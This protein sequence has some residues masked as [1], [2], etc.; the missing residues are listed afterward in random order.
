MNNLVIK[1]TLGFKDETQTFVI[2]T[3]QSDT[4]R[5]VIIQIVDELTLIDFSNIA[6][7]ILYYENYSLDLTSSID[8]VN[9][10][11]SFSIDDLAGNLTG[12]IYCEI[13]LKDI[14]GNVIL[15]TNKFLI[16][17]K[18]IGGDCSC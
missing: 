5:E 16:R 18:E 6:T 17:I 8:R 12:D 1:K 14:N 13:V 4:N 2:S 9:N 3:K 15:I 10:S 11:I 7:V